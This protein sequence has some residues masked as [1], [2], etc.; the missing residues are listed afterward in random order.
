[1]NPRLRLLTALV[2]AALAAVPASGQEV[3]LDF[4]SA[5]LPQMAEQLGRQTGFEFSVTTPKE[6]Q[7]LRR[8]YVC[9]SRPLGDVLR[10]LGALFRAD[11]HSPA[12][13]GFVASGPGKAP[14][15]QVRAGPYYVRV[16]RISETGDPAAMLLTLVISAPDEARAEAVAGLGRELRILDN[17]SRPLIPPVGGELRASAAPRV[18]LTEYQ[19]SYVLRM[20]DSKTGRVRSLAGSVLLYRSVTPLRFEFPLDG[21]EPEAAQ[22]QGGVEAQLERASLLG[23]DLSVSTRLSWPEAAAVIGRGISR[24]PL[25]YVVDERGRVYR[26][27]SP[28]IS[29]VRDNGRL[30]WEQ[31]FRFTGLEARPVRLVYEMLRKERPEATLPFR[32]HTIPLPGRAWGM[33]DR[34]RTFLAEEGGGAVTFRVLD[35]DGQPVEGDLSLGISRWEGEYWGPW[36]W[37]ELATDP[38]GTLTIEQLR[39]GRYRLL[40][41]FRPQP[42]SLPLS[43]GAPVETVVANGKDARAAPLKLPIRAAAIGR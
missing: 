36:R 31:R 29:R 15:H 43:E 27:W 11:F 9:R 8:S 40:R 41:A 23:R 38:D 28:G 3:T 42:G 6:R 20:P 17:L 33:G 7:A 14:T 5:T 32:L 24:T 34:L 37:N 10:D 16:E 25:P 22:Q 30:Q 35:R 1:M 39:P 4:R 2:G 13:S 12:P 26:D 19:Q 18:R 21:A